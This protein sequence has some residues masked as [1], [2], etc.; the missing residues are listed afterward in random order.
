M[1]EI[2]ALAEGW[3]GGLFCTVEVYELESSEKDDTVLVR[4]E[5]QEKP[6][7]S[8]VDSPGY[9]GSIR[10]S[11]TI[12]TQPDGVGDRIVPLKGC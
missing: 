12:L 7:G 6:G 10:R 11:T 5:I 1:R 2:A 4:R 8:R 9:L 3:L